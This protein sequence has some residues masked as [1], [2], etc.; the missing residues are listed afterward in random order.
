MND[1][2]DYIRQ[3]LIKNFGE[4]DAEAM[5]ANYIDAHKH[6]KKG[7]N[8]I[9]VR[10]EGPMLTDDEVNRINTE[11][12]SYNLQLS[13]I[14]SS[15]VVEAHF[16]YHEIIGSLTI[17]QFIYGSIISGIIIPAVYDGIKYLLKKMLT[18][19]EEYKD[20]TKKDTICLNIVIDEKTTVYLLLDQTVNNSNIEAVLE[21]SI[22]QIKWEVENKGSSSSK[23]KSFYYTTDRNGNVKFLE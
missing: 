6:I 14:D 11:F 3:S 2:K 8:L 1:S 19:K 12:R 22:R 13:Y 23:N 21:K 7:D 17:N 16:D 10:I 20:R 5:Y 18:T 4:I 15:R 9:S